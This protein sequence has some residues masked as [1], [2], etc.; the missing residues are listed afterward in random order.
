M[1]NPKYAVAAYSNRCVG[2]SMWALCTLVWHDA[3]VARTCL[4]VTPYRD[5]RP[6]TFEE[7]LTFLTDNGVDVRI[8]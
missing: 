8:A 2:E 6:P 4:G 1:Q 7:L 5:R 3:D